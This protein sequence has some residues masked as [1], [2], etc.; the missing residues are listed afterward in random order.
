MA[1]AHRLL[2]G[3]TGFE[4]GYAPK[5]CGGYPNPAAY[6]KWFPAWI[7]IEDRENVDGSC[8]WLLRILTIGR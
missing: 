2:D 8:S 7:R 1:L 5:Q 6:I 4:F 3:P